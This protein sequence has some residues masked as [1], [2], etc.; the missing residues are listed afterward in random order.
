MSAA[1]DL[2]E[3]LERETGQRVD[4]PG[5]MAMIGLLGAAVRL[6][7]HAPHRCTEHDD[8]ALGIV[9][10]H[11]MSPA[12]ARE[13]QANDL[14]AEMLVSGISPEIFC[15]LLR[16]A[17]LKGRAIENDPEFNAAHGNP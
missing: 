8:V 3:R 15:K 13:Q 1:S 4:D 16:G 7:R 2:I 12:Y 11:R 5:S 6:L 14:L 17:R 10:Q 9:V